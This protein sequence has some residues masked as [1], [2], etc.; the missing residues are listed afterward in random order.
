MLLLGLVISARLRV[1]LRGSDWIFCD[2]SQPLVRSCL[3]VRH[4]EL[5]H[6]RRDHVGPDDVEELRCAECSKAE[7][8]VFPVPLDLELDAEP[9]LHELD[10]GHTFFKGEGAGSDEHLPCEDAPAT[11]LVDAVLLRDP[12]VIHVPDRESMRREPVEPRPRHS[13]VPLAVGE[14][15]EPGIER[16]REGGQTLGRG[17]CHCARPASTMPH[18]LHV[19][20]KMRLFGAWKSVSKVPSLWVSL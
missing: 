20:A 3:L 18:S 10:Q 5:V 14:A 9:F 13:L 2:K 8:E 19:G 1:F 12:A 11:R 6:H 15:A 4:V 17:L 7:A 16:V